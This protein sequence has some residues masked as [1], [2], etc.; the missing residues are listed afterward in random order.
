MTSEAQILIDRYH[1]GT[2]EAVV[3]QF[4]EIFKDSPES[5][6]II[7]NPIFQNMVHLSIVMGMEAGK[8]AFVEL[9]RASLEEILHGVH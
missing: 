3:S 5:M 6:E 8:D 4:R 7:E 9:N 2:Y 1:Q